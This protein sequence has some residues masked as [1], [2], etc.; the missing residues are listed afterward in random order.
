MKHSIYV[1]LALCLA[2]CVTV[3]GKSVQ[4]ATGDF[5]Y[6]PATGLCRNADGETGLNAPMPADLF[7]GHDPATNT[8]TGGNAECVDFSEFNFADHIGMGYPVLD[9][10]NFRGARFA[11][12]RIFF[13]NVTNGDFAGADLR[14]L[15]YGY[16]TITGQGDAH[17]RGDTCPVRSDFQIQCT[18]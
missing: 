12:A 9:Q 5:V 2:A 1:L 10:W 7:A 11:K 8:Y 13:A 4:A 14:E 15:K 17:T 16:A 3:G 6:D 18:R